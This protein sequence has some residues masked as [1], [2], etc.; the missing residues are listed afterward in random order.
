LKE[1]KKGD[2]RVTFDDENAF[3]SHTTGLTLSHFASSLED[4]HFKSDEGDIYSKTTEDEPQYHVALLSSMCDDYYDNVDQ[5]KLD[6]SFL[7]FE[8]CECSDD[9]DN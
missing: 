7:R 4:V 8:S 9:S 3:F 1:K 6:Y 5:H 2:T